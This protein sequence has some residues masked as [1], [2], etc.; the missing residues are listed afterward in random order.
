MLPDGFDR[1]YRIKNRVAG[2]YMMGLG[3]TV[4]WKNDTELR[5]NNIFKP[6]RK[7]KQNRKKIKEREEKKTYVVQPTSSK[8]KP[9]EKKKT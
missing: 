2:V 1:P 9:K 4:F 8:A 5:W 7:H 3:G 6:L